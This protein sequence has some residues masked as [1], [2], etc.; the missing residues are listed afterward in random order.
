MY[1]C[2][3]HVNLAFYYFYDYYNNFNRKILNCGIK[4]K[5]VT[6]AGLDGCVVAN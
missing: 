3:S 6:K 4:F 2:A 5:P 1:K